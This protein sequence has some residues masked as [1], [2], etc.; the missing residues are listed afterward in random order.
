VAVTVNV[1]EPTAVA[2]VVEIVRVVVGLAVVTVV[3]LNDAVA[4][5]GSADVVRGKVVHGLPFP[6]KPTVTVYTADPPGETVTLPGLT[7]TVFGLA[8]VNVFCATDAD[9]V[10]V[11]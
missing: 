7:A 4:P 5:A 11:R 3:G 1:G 6:L 2:A 8:S 9:P 10:A